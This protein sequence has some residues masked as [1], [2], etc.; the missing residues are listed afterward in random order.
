MSVQE[1]NNGQN[2][3]KTIHITEFIFESSGSSLHGSTDTGTKL[4]ASLQIFTR[5]TQ[6]LPLDIIQNVWSKVVNIDTTNHKETIVNTATNIEQ[7]ISLMPL[8]F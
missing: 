7:A 5:L 3:N 2:N 8:A 1:I 4:E 6:F